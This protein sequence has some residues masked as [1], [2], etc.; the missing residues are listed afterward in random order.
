MVN[1]LA[2][3]GI[4]GRDFLLSHANNLPSGDVDSIRRAGAHIFR[5]PLTELQMG[6][7]GPV[8]LDKE[9]Y[10]IASLGVD[11]HSA[12]SS[13]MVTQMISVLQ[14]PRGVRHAELEKHNKWVSSHGPMV[15]DVYS[16]GTVLGARA[17]GLGEELG[18]LRVGKKADIVIFSRDSPLMLAAAHRDPVAAV[19]LHSSVRDVQT[20]IVDSVIMK[21]EGALID[22]LHSQRP[23]KRPAGRQPP[24]EMARHCA[25]CATE[26]PGNRCPDQQPGQLRCDARRGYRRISS[27]PWWLA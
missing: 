11:C 18:S 16:F 23:G 15:E 9:C 24:G 14:W 10:D 17:I 25:G 13:S 21:L 2:Q 27:Q 26:S 3:S 6:H 8:C 4:L 19:V 12:C 20:V 7:G 22:V 5:T 1:K